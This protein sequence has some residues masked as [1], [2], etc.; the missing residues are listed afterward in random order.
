MNI[1]GDRSSLVTRVPSLAATETHAA[2]QITACS[3]SAFG[4]SQR[5]FAVH[6]WRSGFFPE[7]FTWFVGNIHC[8]CG[9]LLKIF[10]S[11]TFLTTL[12]RPDDPRG[13]LPFKGHKARFEL[14]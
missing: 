11:K 10:L 12:T 7:L 5:L 2:E 14:I 1:D 6:H 8:R 13:L 4:F 3:R 9:P